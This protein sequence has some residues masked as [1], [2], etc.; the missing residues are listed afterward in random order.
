MPQISLI[1]G[2]TQSAKT[3]KAF[4]LLAQNIPVDSGTLV[5]F[6]TQANS[7][8]AAKQIVNRATENNELFTVLSEISRPLPYIE[9][10]DEDLTLRIGHKNCMLVDFWHS[11][12]MRHM[13]QVVTICTHRWENIVIVIDEADQGSEK[14]VKKRLEYVHIVEGLMRRPRNLH[15]IFVTATVAHFSACINELVDAD[16]LHNNRS[17]SIVRSI[18]HRSDI[19]HYFVM[20]ATTY[21]GPSWF[22]NDNKDKWWPLSYRKQQRGETANAYM[23]YRH[24]TLVDKLA[25]LSETQKEMSLIV[26]TPAQDEQKVIARRIL[27]CGYNVTVILN[28]AHVKN[29][30]VFYLSET[31]TH[32]DKKVMCEWQV[33]YSE[34]N[35]LCKEANISL[36]LPHI[37]Q[38]ACFMGTES[39]ERI[40][41]NVEA[42]YPEE[43]DKLNQMFNMMQSLRKVSKRRPNDYPTK[44]CVALIAG[45]IAGRGIT[46]QNA[47]IDFVCSSF[48]FMGKR[49]YKQRGAMNA[50]KFGRACG[51]LAET[52]VEKQREPI[53]I[54]SPGVINDAYINEKSLL[55]KAKDMENGE[56]IS[57][58]EFIPEEEWQA[59]ASEC[60]NRVRQEVR[61]KKREARV[62]RELNL[63][64]LNN[65]T[66]ENANGS[67]NENNE[68][69]ES[70]NIT[71]DAMSGMTLSGGRPVASPLID[72][73]TRRELR[74]IEQQREA[75]SLRQQDHIIIPAN[76]E[77]MLRRGSVYRTLLE[78]IAQKPQGCTIRQLRSENN[79][80][81]EAINRSHRNQ[82]Y[83]LGTKLHY[84]AKYE[85]TNTWYVTELG[86]QILA[87]T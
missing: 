66:E 62:S 56:R 55:E 60:T 44:P 53:L 61:A 24:A 54:S 68:N 76:Q 11:R 74:E 82:F 79:T 58:K 81:Y 48:C 65:H 78:Y 16:V 1:D 13:N 37:L 36:T 17:H 39:Q 63:L 23:N 32:E 12:N 35:M 5:L 10:I 30:K 8:S 50:Q 83:T 28:S 45:Q 41:A 49:D 72:F 47:Q 38:V 27:M 84:V 14:G 77:P 59:F 87:R 57:L 19:A 67:H 51:M 2:L 43:W 75:E 86:R 34:M 71:I 7:T 69:N 20:P 52:F 46:I 73:V 6:I 42:N 15:V 18:L 33:P 64:N 22:L 4:E 21:I 85:G 29:Y 40:H 26:T 25:F 3:W 9:K 70:L 80:L 31:E